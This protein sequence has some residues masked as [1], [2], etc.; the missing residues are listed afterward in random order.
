M[1]R[2]SRSG[3]LLLSAAGLVG[4]AVNPPPVRVEGEPAAIQ[5]LAGEWVGEY[6]SP[7][8]GRTGSILFRLEAGKDTAYGDVV[9]IPRQRPSSAGDLEDSGDVG[10]RVQGVDIQ[11]VHCA[12]V[13]VKGLLAPYTDPDCGCV[14]VTE[15]TGTV[16]GDRIEGTFTAW[17]TGGGQ[18]GGGT[19]HVTRKPTAAQRR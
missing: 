3:L 19:W 18:I 15:F 9:M 2:A 12:G 14:V 4:C 11:F 6:M 1:T 13:Q 5:G 7:E 10:P 17:R 16:Q 8:T